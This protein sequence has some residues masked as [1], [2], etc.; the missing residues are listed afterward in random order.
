MGLRSNPAEAR[1]AVDRRAA[2]RFCRP[3]RGLIR[4]ASLTHGSRRWAIH[5]P[6]ASRAAQNSF[7][8]AKI[9]GASSTKPPNQTATDLPGPAYPHAPR[10]RRRPPVSRRLT[11]RF[12][13]LQDG[14]IHFYFLYFVM[15]TRPQP[16][17]YRLYTGASR[18][19]P[20]IIALPMLCQFGIYV[21]LKMFRRPVPVE[22]KANIVRTADLAV[23]A[24]SLCPQSTCL[25]PAA[26]W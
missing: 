24:S 1:A 16:V 15:V 20:E 10:S 7:C 17:F 12:T 21:K 5:L 25:P 22:N 18:K 26:A 4:F 6:P 11:G 3:L 9:L 13:G 23:R 2:G 8:P 14:C 19:T